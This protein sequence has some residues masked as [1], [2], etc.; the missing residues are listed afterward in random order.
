ML[1][2]A[3]ALL[4]TGCS[5]AGVITIND[6]DISAYRAG[7]YLH[8]ASVVGASDGSS[9]GGLKINY[10][11]IHIE[12]SGTGNAVDSKYLLPNQLQYLQNSG[13]L[14]EQDVLNPAPLSDFVVPLEPEQVITKFNPLQLRH[15]TQANQRINVYINSMQAKDLKGS[16]PNEADKNSPEK[17]PNFKRY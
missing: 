13:R 7:N 5:A 2:R 3:E 15:G 1:W 8:G 14:Y 4:G 16:I 12:N 9:I 17:K 11:K 10:G 6:G